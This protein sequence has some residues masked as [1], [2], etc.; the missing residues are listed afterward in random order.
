MKTFTPVNPALLEIGAADWALTPDFVIPAGGGAAA[1]ARR[2]LMTPMRYLHL[3][4]AYSLETAGPVPYLRVAELAGY[5]GGCSTVDAREDESGLTRT[6]VDELR[7]FCGPT[8]LADG[9]RARAVPAALDR[10]RLPTVLG[11]LRLGEDDLGQELL[12]GI[13]YRASSASEKSVIEQRVFCFGP[14]YTHT[15]LYPPSPAPLCTVPRALYSTTLRVLSAG[16]GGDREEGGARLCGG[17][18]AET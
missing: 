1:V 18:A 12:D 5:L 15:L 16:R 17:G 9:A 11:S 4:S 8:D 13:A 10:L 3:L 2:A 6:A 7:R 14:R